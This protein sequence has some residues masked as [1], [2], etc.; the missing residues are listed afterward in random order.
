MRLTL[1][2]YGNQSTLGYPG[3]VKLTNGKVS[4]TQLTRATMKGDGAHYQ[5]DFLQQLVE[6]TPVV[7][8]VKDFLPATISLFSLGREIEIVVGG[9]MRYIDNL[10][11]TNEGRLV[12][13][14]TKLWR[15][16]ESAREVIA[17][18]LEYGMALSAI[19]ILEL[20]KGAQVAP[21]ANYQ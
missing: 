12:L 13:V 20:E 10:L 7:L 21:R 1:E 15:N 3:L 14:E 18:T 9:Q 6:N 19:S 11:V 8:P 17:Q 2:N 16:P 5:E 4:C